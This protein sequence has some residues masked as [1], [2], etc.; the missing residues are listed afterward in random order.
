[1]KDWMQRVIASKAKARSDLARLP[2]S[3]K[4][5]IL[6]KLRDRSQLIASSPLRKQAEA[7]ALQRRQSREYWQQPRRKS[8]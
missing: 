7:K 1:M 5:A 6:E 2:F 4:V 8:S 3:A